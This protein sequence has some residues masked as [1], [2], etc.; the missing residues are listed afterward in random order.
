MEQHNHSSLAEFLLLGFPKVGHVRGWVFVLLLLAYLFTLCGNMLIILVIRLDAALHTPMYHFVSIL[1][2]LELLYTTTTI[3]KMLTNLLSEKKTISFAGCL[4]QTY[5][6]HS[7]GASECYL[8]TAMAYDRYLAICR[9]LHYPAIITPTLCVRMAAGCWAC[10]FLCPIS[11]VILICQLPFCGYNE[12]QHIFCDFPPLLSLA[13]KDTSTNV[14]VD[15]AINAFIILITFFF[16]MVSYGRII[17]A[18]LRIKTSAGRKK[19]FSTCASHLIVVLIFF[20]SIIF[21]YV[22][23]K[24]SY[25]VTLDRTLAVVYSLLTPLVNPIIYS[26]RHKELIKAIKRAIFQKW[27]ES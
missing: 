9:P 23:L 10:G 8:L 27:R 18:V 21:M 13:C 22:R 3:P 4:L 24:K 11:E 2:F 14:L 16:I 1:S 25:S 12:I 7:L 5:F 15:F 6:F 26:L 17:G 19:A 20:G